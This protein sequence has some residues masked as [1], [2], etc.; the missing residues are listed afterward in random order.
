MFNVLQVVRFVL[1]VV[2]AL[3]AS[4]LLAALGI[5][6]FGPAENTLLIAFTCWLFGFALHRLS[7]HY[8]EWSPRASFK[9]N[10]LVGAGFAFALAFVGPADAADQ[11][12]LKLEGVRIEE[13]V[14]DRLIIKDRSGRRVGTIDTKR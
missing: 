14:G 10:A 7:R 3:F 9:I 2:L 4:A 11:S 5:V 1:A 8:A 12:P 6:R 13:G